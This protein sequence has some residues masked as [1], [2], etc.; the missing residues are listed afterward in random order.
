[1]DNFMNLQPESSFIHQVD[2]YLISRCKKLLI[3]QL[4]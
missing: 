2:C 1:M 4:T 3:N